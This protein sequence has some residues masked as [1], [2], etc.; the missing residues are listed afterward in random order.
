MSGNIALVIPVNGDISSEFP[1][2]LLS[3][4]RAVEPNGLPGTDSERPTDEDDEELDPGP[5]EVEGHALLSEGPAWFGSIS[6]NAVA[7]KPIWS[8]NPGEPGLDEPSPQVI[9]SGPSSSFILSSS[10][11]SFS[12][13]FWV[14]LFCF[15]SSYSH[16]SALFILRQGEQTGL[17]PS[18]FCSQ[19]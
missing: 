17:W 7:P 19:G 12:L 8:K 16:S 13:S 2:A 18:H 1:P 9:D 3:Q 10:I 6:P 5:A 4:F 14:R 15:L 11:A